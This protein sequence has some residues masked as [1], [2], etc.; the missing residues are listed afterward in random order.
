MVQA[1]V[2][3]RPPSLLRKISQVVVP[4][5]PRAAGVVVQVR[6]PSKDRRAYRLYW[7]LPMAL[8]FQLGD[9]A[10]ISMTKSLSRKPR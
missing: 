4:F 10:Y 9:Q 8:V 7:S 5:P 3:S 6:P 2:E 1:G